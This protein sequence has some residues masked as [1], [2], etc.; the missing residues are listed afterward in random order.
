MEAKKFIVAIELGSSKITGVAGKKNPDGSI[1][2]LAVVREKST[3][4][5]RKGTVYNIEK[6]VQCVSNIINE[7]K[8]KLNSDIAQVYVGI[9]G[10]SLRSVRNTITKDFENETAITDDIVAELS[11]VNRSEDY[12]EHVIQDTV[13]QEYK[14]DA[15]YQ[16]EPVSISCRHF[17]SNF[18]N[19]LTKKIFNKNLKSCFDSVGVNIAGRI[20]APEALADVILTDVEKNI[21]CALID[22]GYG[23]TTVSVY[24]KGLLRH[25]CVIPLGGN[26][27]TRDIASLQVEESTAES[28]KLRYGSAYTKVKD[29]PVDEMISLDKE[30][31]VEKKKF[32]SIVSARICEIIENVKHQIPKEYL[33]KLAGGIILTGGGSNMKDISAAFKN[34]MEIE[35]VRIAD[36]VNTDIKCKNIFVARDGSM[37]TV[38][39]I[40]SAGTMNCAQTEEAENNLL[41]NN[42]GENVEAGQEE[43]AA[44]NKPE[45]E[46]VKTEPVA[47]EQKTPV[48]DE[49]EEN[50]EEIQNEE[51][52]KPR[53]KG[54]LKKLFSDCKHFLT[55]MVTEDDNDN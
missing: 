18:L 7:L 34:I 31:T 28:L 5:I 32:L 2:L 9:G 10:Q 19:I 14:V 26:S 13:I 23:T 54:K 42:E 53:K 22:L 40:L 35:K 29:V 43:N 3:G 1:T 37:N 50:N 39:G 41:I 21:G 25:L 8:K 47:E 16:L 27:I 30:R 15:R 4:C 38:L 49:K 46:P 44:E 51:E 24:Y 45:Q 55:S 48:I 33:D 12:K 6:T 36:Y 52:N 17:E 20:L 11:R